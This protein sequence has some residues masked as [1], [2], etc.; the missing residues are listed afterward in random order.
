MRK[1]LSVAENWIHLIFILGK[2]G[3]DGQSS[4][5]RNYVRMYIF[6]VCGG[7]WLLMKEDITSDLSINVF[8]LFIS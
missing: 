7:D 4:I 2:I 3:P 1:I 6:C 8:L 5:V